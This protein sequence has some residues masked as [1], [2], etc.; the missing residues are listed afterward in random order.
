MAELLGAMMCRSLEP[1]EPSL[2][3][4]IQ[5]ECIRLADSRLVRFGL[6]RKLALRLPNL[7]LDER[8]VLI[9]VF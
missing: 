9:K 5:A 3:V 7:R 1:D 2:Q 6:A 4:K 8:N